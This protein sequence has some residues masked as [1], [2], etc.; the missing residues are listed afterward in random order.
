MDKHHHSD[1]EYNE[2]L[3]IGQMGKHSHDELHHIGQ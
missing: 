3:D 1:K 2:G